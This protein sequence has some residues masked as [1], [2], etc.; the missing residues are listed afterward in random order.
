[1]Y[2]GKGY[3]KSYKSCQSEREALKEPNFSIVD[4]RKLGRVRKS[5]NT[6]HP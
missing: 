6:Q 3:F 5:I 4:R 2:N 1:M